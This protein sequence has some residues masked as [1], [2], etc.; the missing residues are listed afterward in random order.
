[1][2]DKEKNFTLSLLLA[3]GIIICLTLTGFSQSVMPKKDLVFSQVFAG[4]AGSDTYYS[5]IAVTNRGSRTYYGTLWFVTGAAG[6]LWTPKVNGTRISDL[7]LDVVIGPDET[8]SYQVTETSFKVGYAVFISDDFSLDNHIEGNLTYY[9]SRGGSLL[10]AIG[11]PESQE[12]R[13]SSLPF[14]SFRDVGLALAHPDLFES[15][16]PALVD[17]WLFD[18]DGTQIANTVITLDP[19][20]HFARYLWELDWN[21]SIPSNFGPVGKVEI[22]SSQAISGISMLISPGSEAGAQI[23]T[24]PL[25]G[26]PLNYAITFDGTAGA[27]TGETYTGELT[28]W[29][30]G[31]FV[32]GYLQLTEINGSPVSNPDQTIPIL[33]QGQLIGTELDLTCFTNTSWPTVV[34]YGTV[35]YLYVSNFLPDGDISEGW[36]GTYNFWDDGT[37]VSEGNLAI[38]NTIY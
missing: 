16:A 34:N 15:G 11:V 23:S 28:L 10:D 35:L 26:T 29:I 20:E 12:I 18:E 30:E 37:P 24:L 19:G 33:V 1:M 4:P 8:R 3:I 31:F 38:D 6:D 27:S 14:D 36:W 7:G 21:T 22:S 32:K 5:S 2:L 17:V 13:I 25:G 9:S